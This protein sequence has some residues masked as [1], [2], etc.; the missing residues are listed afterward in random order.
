MDGSK[1]VCERFCGF[2]VRVDRWVKEFDGDQTRIA[3]AAFA[4]AKEP[5][6][7]TFRQ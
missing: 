1:L 6:G 7:D 5:S 4:S 2:L 3:A